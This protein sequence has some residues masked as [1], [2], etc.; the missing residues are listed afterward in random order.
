[1]KPAQQKPE[2]LPLSS[3]LPSEDSAEMTVV[4]IDNHSTADN[5]EH[6]KE[7]SI[8]TAKADDAEKTDGCFLNIDDAV[9]SCNVTRAFR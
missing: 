4:R 8:G 1:M 5:K 9:D 3:C 7:L 2:S 6:S